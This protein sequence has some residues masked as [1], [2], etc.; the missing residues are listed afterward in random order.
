MKYETG[1]FWYYNEKSFSRHDVPQLR[2]DRNLT[3]KCTTSLIRCQNHNGEVIDR[4][5]LVF[6][7]HKL[8]LNVSLVD[9]CVWIRLNVRISLLEKESSIGSMLLSAWGAT[10]IQWNIQMPRLHLVAD[11]LIIM[12]NQ[13]RTSQSGQS[14]RTISEI[15]SALHRLVSVVRFIAERGLA[16]RDDENFGWPRKFYQK[17]FETF[18]KQILIKE[19]AMLLVTGFATVS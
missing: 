1:F 14:V 10:S 3:W 6:V 9:W 5:L 16:F 4:S 12:K 11:V 2:K 15:P 17:I 18:F 19:D 13:Y 7:L 8:V